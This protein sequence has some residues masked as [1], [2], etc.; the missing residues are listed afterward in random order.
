[1]QV[2]ELDGGSG[3]RADWK[4]HQVLGPERGRLGAAMIP[5]LLGQ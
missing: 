4:L 2:Q 5:D 1:M 3:P